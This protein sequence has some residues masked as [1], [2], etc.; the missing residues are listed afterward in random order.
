MAIINPTNFP[1]TKYHP[2][3]IIVLLFGLSSCFA[4]PLIDTAGTGGL[5]NGDCR[6]A[7]FALGRDSTIAD[8]VFW[9]FKLG[10]AFF[11]CQD[12]EQSVTQLKCCIADSCRLR[13]VALEIIGDVETV[14]ARPSEAATA[15]LLAQR[16][17]LPSPVIL[18]ISQKMYGLVK[19]H[20]ELSAS[21]PELAALAAEK[22]FLLEQNT[23]T[24]T[25]RIDSLLTTAQ[26]KAADS[27]LSR[28]LDTTGCKKNCRMV[29]LVASRK[30][31][32]SAFSTALLFRIARAAYACRDFSVADTFCARAEARRD[33]ARS[34]PARERGLVKGLVAYSCGRYAAAD[35]VLRDVVRKY[36]PTPDVVLALARSNRALGGDSAA[37]PWYN[38]FVK[39]YPK[40]PNAPDVY[41]HLAWKQEEDEHYDQAVSLYRKLFQLKK[42]SSKCDEAYF[43]QGLCW[44]KAGRYARACSTFAAFPKLFE[45]SWLAA[46]ALYW[47]GKCLLSLGKADE[48]AGALCD[49]VRSSPTDFYAFRARES[50][51]L[52][53]DTAC[54][55]GVD[56]SFGIDATRAWIDTLLPLPRQPLSK[57]DSLSYGRGT[58]LALCGLT[59]QAARF[60]DGLENRYPSNLGLQF[61]LAFL[62]RYGNDPTASFRAGRRLLWHIPPASRAAMPLPLFSILY[63]T[64]FSD[65]VASE[66]RAYSIDP[67]LVLSVIR[68]E[69]VFDADALSR[70]G[71]IGL[72]QIMPFTGRAIAQKLGEAFS[73]DSLLN[74]AVNIRYGTFYLRQ[75]LDQFKGNTVLALASYNGGPPRASEW[76]T[77]NKRKTFD[78]FIEDIGYAE[79]RGYV[80]RVLANY[81]TYRAFSPGRPFD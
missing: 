42:M 19:A 64:P 26:W 53:T 16:D 20:P 50:L 13:G 35:K 63:P 40:H 11:N 66:A 28:E 36:G 47:K 32:D 76:Y 48:A 75:L 51:R 10:V 8:S 45:D 70:A 34:V 41:W 15:Y 79:T 69:S 6:Q 60:L 78:L 31:P 24:I 33:Y 38:R 37:E 22:K 18:D 65:R 30:P 68:Q 80:K 56:T 12:Y 44:Y 9:H 77:K 1:K 72:M 62:Y 67:Y 59:A 43:R 57:S 39:L 71:A 17:S 81:W 58:L 73:T 49:V 54:F 3:S 7:L 74:P 52:S 23:D 27:A 21:F 2:V 61:D 4:S 55:P 14:R 29:D 25:P 46:G 5:A